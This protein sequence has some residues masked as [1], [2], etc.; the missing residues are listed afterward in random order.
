MTNRCLFRRWSLILSLGLV[1]AFSGR[2]TAQG[3]L[4]LSV[5]GNQNV[6]EGSGPFQMTFQVTNNTGSTLLLDYA[7]ASITP[8][9]PDPSDLASFTGTNGSSGLASASLYILAGQTGSYTYNVYT[10][11][12]ADG[13]DFGKNRFDF[14]SEYQIYNGP[15]NS[16]PNP[17]N[18][19]SAGGG[20]T[21]LGQNGGGF[22]ENQAALNTLLGFGPLNFGET[23][24]TNDGANP[25]AGIFVASSISFIGDPNPFDHSPIITVNDVGVPE[26]SSIILAATAALV[27]IG[28]GRYHRGR[29]R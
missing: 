1:S 28:Y 21:F 8:T 4:P 27:L 19:S 6:V 14:F 29:A 25:T 23:L 15:L 20:V 2:A 12:P 16:L 22:S 10:P 13:D 3:V 7:F 18:A 26:P 9:G 24:F 5:P 11:N 17:N